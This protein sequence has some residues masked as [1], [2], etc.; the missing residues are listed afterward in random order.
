MKKSFVSLFLALVLVMVV[1][2]GCKAALPT[3]EGNNDNYTAVTDG[4]D[5]VEVTDPIEDTKPVDITDPVEVT[6]P[7]DM[8]EPAE[9]VPELV[10][11][12][13]SIHK[14]VNEKG[15]T[16]LWFVV[17]FKTLGYDLDFMNPFKI[18]N[19]KNGEVMTDDFFGEKSKRTVYYG[20]VCTKNHEDS[21]ALANEYDCS[22]Y[23]VCLSYKEDI[24]FEDLD[25]FCC[26][27]YD[28]LEDGE[29][30]SLQFNS[31]MSDITTQQ[32]F[33]HGCTLFELDGV[34]YVN[35]GDSGA[36]SGINTFGSAQGIVSINGTL[37]DLANSL[38]GKID[39]IYAP[40][41]RKS[42]TEGL[43]QYKY[44]QMFDVPANCSM[45]VDVSDYGS[46]L[47]VGLRSTDGHEFTDEDVRLSRLIN[48]RYKFEDGRTMTFIVF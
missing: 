41:V 5:C 35:S 31:E 9:E 14:K 46:D 16:E 11:N 24:N 3:N 8:T 4:S 23:V 13:A 39:F 30:I 26:P 34:F 40:T 19:N 20:N 43:V 2:A 48:L 36:Y 47:Y 33:I 27:R 15:W 28:S 17:E 42:E 22:Q 38:N 6:E 37:N 21:F 25:I 32:E 45:Y 29:E 44:L 7:T 18:V 12:M 10:Y 1:F